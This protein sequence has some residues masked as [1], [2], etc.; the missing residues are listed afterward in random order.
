MLSLVTC[1]IGGSFLVD[2]FMDFYTRNNPNTPFE[3]IVVVDNRLTKSDWTKWKKV[4]SNW[5]NL[6]V[7]NFQ[8]KRT[9]EFLLKSV[10]RYH[11][12]LSIFP[13][14]FLDV[15]SVNIEA[16]RKDKFPKEDEHLFVN[17]GRLYNAGLKIAKYE[18]ICCGPFDFLYNFDFR[19]AVEE[20][21][22]ISP[23]LKP[24]G[25]VT[26]V[27]LLNI[28]LVPFK[29]LRFNHWI[30]IH[31]FKKCI[32]ERNPRIKGFSEEW[33][34][35]AFADEK[36]KKTFEYIWGPKECSLDFVMNNHHFYK[37]EYP[38]LDREKEVFLWGDYPKDKINVISNSF[39][40]QFSEDLNHLQI[41]KG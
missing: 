35:R 6:T 39:R 17:T 16:Y 36:F 8:K 37:K 22:T 5:D 10:Q 30:G 28:P 26:Q 9:I 14:D 38:F 2:P 32:L 24:N 13:I 33:I 12:L 11:S 21:N 25:I 18:N 3:V 1:S 40:K 27:P 31:L 20:L 7:V 41:L 29:G 15:L 34:G 19:K 4:K 23:Y